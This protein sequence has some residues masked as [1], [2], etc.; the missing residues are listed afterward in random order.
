MPG[1]Q[2]VQ[3]QGLAQ[4]QRELKAIDKDLPK[5]LKTAA[6]AAAEVVATDARSRA[7]SQGSVL[8]KS[9]P[10]FKAAA[11]Q[12]RAKI[13]LGGPQY[14]FALGAEFGGRGRPTTQQ[15]LPH[16]GRQGY[17]VYPAIRGTREEFIQVYE[18]ALD[19]LTRRAFPD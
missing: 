5:E 11:E 1:E 18:R 15:F 16:R 6:L 12:R 10:S 17:A 2:P 19:Q 8:A 3:I 14:P 13:T 4:F 9:A 7:E